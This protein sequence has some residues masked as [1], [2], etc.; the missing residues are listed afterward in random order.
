MNVPL[1][2]RLLLLRTCRSTGCDLLKGAS[3][4]LAL[5]AVAPAAAACLQRPHVTHDLAEKRVLIVGG[6]PRMSGVN[7]GTFELLPQTRNGQLHTTVLPT[8]GASGQPFRIAV[9][10]FPPHPVPHTVV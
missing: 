9:P 5:A 1:C 4:S 7:D 6:P 10:F 8:A 2:C 3:R